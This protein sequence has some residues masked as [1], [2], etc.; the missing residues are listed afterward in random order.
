M[1]RQS[2]K[3]FDW[4]SEKNYPSLKSAP[5]DK[6]HPLIRLSYA[7]ENATEEFKNETAA[8]NISLT[9]IICTSVT[10]DKEDFNI[11]EKEF[12]N[13][14]LEKIMILTIKRFHKVKSFHWGKFFRSL[15]RCGFSE[16]EMTVQ[17]L[18]V[19]EWK[20]DLDKIESNFMRSG[21][22]EPSAKPTKSLTPGASREIGSKRRF[23][24]D[25]LYS[26]W[27]TD[28]WLEYMR[29][30]KGSTSS[31][32]EKNTEESSGSNTESA[33]EAEETENE[34]IIQVI[35]SVSSEDEV[36]ETWDE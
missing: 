30:P 12:E 33:G 29:T 21:S 5:S 1:I 11:S 23:K 17:K 32:E 19:E 24:Y 7:L 16:P 34:P 36:P 13:L 28:E 6:F 2:W 14:C 4:E 20:F 8:S 15:K 18:L 25:G 9:I 3:N 27:K 31:E 35:L 10:F 26:R 22:V